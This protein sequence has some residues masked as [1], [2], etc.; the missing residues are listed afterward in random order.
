MTERCRFALLFWHGFAFHCPPPTVSRSFS[1]LFRSVAGIVIFFGALTV[2]AGGWR[3]TRGFERV[4]GV[5]HKWRYWLAHKDRFDVLFV[6]T[7]RLYHQVIPAEFDVGVQTTAP[8]L[9]P[10]RS[11]NFGYD[12]MWPPEQFYLLRRILAERPA[13][14]RYVVFDCM[15]IQPRLDERNARTRR[16]AYWHDWRHTRMAWSAVPDMAEPLLAKWRFATAHGALLLRELTNQGLGA[17]W[18]SYEFGV[19]R[20]KKES[21]WDPP[22]EWKDTEGYGRGTDEPFAGQKLAAYE[23]N[24]RALRLLWPPQQLSPAYY[25]VIQAI[26]A[27]VRA[28]GAEPVWVVTPSDDVTEN[29]TGFPPGVL[30]WHYADPHAFAELYDPAVHYDH[31]HLNHRGAQIFTRM[32]AERFAAEMG[33]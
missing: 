6:G 10:V 13:K 15:D 4:P 19:E 17:E 28:A 9:G 31:A 22:A 27:E 14:L 20:R 11:F 25:R 2:V 32:L 21:R 24:I 8:A 23:A 29:F 7:S 16:T 3:A 30:V 5:Y 12:A 26:D 33:K 18:L 1:Q